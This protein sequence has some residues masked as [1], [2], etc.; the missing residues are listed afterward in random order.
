M[1][2]I[3]L[4]DTMRFLTARLNAIAG[5]DVELALELEQERVEAGQELKI[6][7]RIRSPQRDH[8]MD[9]LR[10]AL[11]GTIQRD[12]Q[13]RDYVKNAE[14]AHGTALPAGHEYVVPIVVVVP[15]DAVLTEDGGQWSLRAQAVLDRTIDPRAE[16][17]IHVTP[18]R[19][20]PEPAESSDPPQA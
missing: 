12:G 14:V 6:W 9:Y 15:M 19:I 4:S 3:K 8:L 5:G 13:W 11:R 10:I 1:S 18:A 16:V 20:P 7:A 17:Q 2:K